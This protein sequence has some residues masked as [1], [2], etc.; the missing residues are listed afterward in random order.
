MESGSDYNKGISD[1]NCIDDEKH[2]KR[3]GQ[4]CADPKG[5]TNNEDG[6]CV[7]LNTDRMLQRDLSDWHIGNREV[8]HTMCLGPQK[9]FNE[10][11]E[12][13]GELSHDLKRNNYELR[14]LWGDP[15]VYCNKETNLIT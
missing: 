7:M 8:L 14:M 1:A 15:V 10:K 12:F 5:A 6:I 4:K 13:T 2:G 9:V 3:I 11:G